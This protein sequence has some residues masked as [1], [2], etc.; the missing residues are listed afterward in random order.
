MGNLLCSVSLTLFE[1][2]NE[3]YVAVGSGLPGLT[4]LI[5]HGLRTSHIFRTITVTAVTAASLVYVFS[6]DERSEPSIF[7]VVVIT[8]CDTGLGFSLAHYCCD[9]GF[10]VFAGFLNEESKGAQELRRKFG[11]RLKEFQVTK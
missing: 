11:G 8:G 9:N 7:K 6:S 1:V 3:L 2:A 10:T 4:V 5:S